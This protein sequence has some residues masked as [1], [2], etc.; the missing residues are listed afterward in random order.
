MAMHQNSVA[1]IVGRRAVTEALQQGPLKAQELLFSGGER[2]APVKRIL[3]MAR[4][5][6]VKVRRVDARRLEAVSGGAAHQGVAL[7]LAASGYARLEDVLE[8]AA[9]AGERALVVAAAHIQDPRNLGA[10]IRSAAG[11]GA[12]GVIIPKDRACPLTPAVSKAAAGALGLI[13]TA[14]V[15]NLAQALERLKEAGLWAVAAASRQAP[16]P[17]ELD[18]NMPLVLVVGSEHKGLGPRLLGA[19]D[20]QVSLPLAPGVESLNA[21]VAAGALLFEIVRQRRRGAPPAGD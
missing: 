9:G 12:Q 19:C 3:D 2:S 11:A 6:G 10:L 7:S 1:Y 20:F 13:P 16:P 15:T 5:A 17:W 18:L 14:R 21:S 4:R 8:R